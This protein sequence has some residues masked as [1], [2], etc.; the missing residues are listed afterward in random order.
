[1]SLAPLPFFKMRVLRLGVEKELARARCK[2]RTHCLVSV[3]ALDGVLLAPSL[4][5]LHLVI[6]ERT[7]QIRPIKFT[8]S[9]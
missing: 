7:C 5:H 2:E 1:M 4:R 8:R 9:V 6:A 3:V